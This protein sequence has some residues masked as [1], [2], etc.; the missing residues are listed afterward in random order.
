MT[1]DK[2]NP[3]F[4][5]Q[6]FTKEQKETKVIDPSELIVNTVQIYENEEDVPKAEPVKNVEY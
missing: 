4:S 5:K 6:Y 2:Q 1:V 3:K